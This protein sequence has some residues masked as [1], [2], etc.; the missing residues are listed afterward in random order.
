V[1]GAVIGGNQILR[2][3][4]FS[5]GGGQSGFGALQGVFGGQAQGHHVDSRLFHLH[6]NFELRILQRAMATGV[7]AVWQ[8]GQ[9]IG[10]ACL[11]FVRFLSYGG[12]SGKV[13]NHRQN[14]G[15]NK[16]DNNMFV[17]QHHS[18]FVVIKSPHYLWCW[19][20]GWWPGLCPG[21]VSL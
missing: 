5:V 21:Q 10:F 19:R 12:I 1:Q 16:R 6:V 18:L 13:G 3:L 2:R 15:N 9:G 4:V 20:L 8:C 11:G 17:G 14:R 7:T